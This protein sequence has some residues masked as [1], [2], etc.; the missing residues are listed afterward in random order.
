MLTLLQSKFGNLGIHKVC[1]FKASTYI[2]I[3]K[4]SIYKYTLLWQESKSI[5]YRQA[6]SKQIHILIVHLSSLPEH[7]LAWKQQLSRQA[8]ATLGMWGGKCHT[9]LQS[10][11]PYLK[12]KNQHHSFIHF[13]YVISSLIIICSY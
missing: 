1:E 9:E 10:S 2:V 11:V 13:Y 3:N 4:E 6:V 12:L 8:L 7:P 5:I